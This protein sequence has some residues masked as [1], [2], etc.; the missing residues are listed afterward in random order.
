MAYEHLLPEPLRGRNERIDE[1][2]PPAEPSAADNGEPTGFVW[3][4]E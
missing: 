4:T 2:L 3:E 1:G